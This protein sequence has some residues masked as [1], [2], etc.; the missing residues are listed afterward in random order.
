MPKLINENIELHVLFEISMALAASLDLENSINNIFEI[1]D[2]KMGMSRAT[3][4]ILNQQTNDI[5]INIAHGITDIEKKR[6]KYKLGEGVTGNVIKK[7]KPA[8]IPNIGSEPL[9]LNKT[10]ARGDTNKKNISFICVP[11]ISGKTSI[12]AI[13]VD[14]LYETNIKYDKD[15]Q[16]LTIIAAMIGQ[17]VKFKQLIEAEKNKLISEN[18]HL[19]YELQQ[20]YNIHN[21]VGNNNAMH[22]IFEEIQLVADSNA[23]V[24][25][26]GES[27]T[28]KELAAYAIHYNSPRASKPFVK[29]NCGAIPENLLESELF[30]YEKGAFTGAVGQKQGK[31]ELADKGTLFFR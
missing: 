15:V 14:K 25:I 24:I 12:G 7:G 8:I 31:L 16:L 18:K 2:K 11:I 22:K 5:V 1:L 13:S 10:K 17:A 30:G 6:G 21:M 20:K 9:F 28:G 4:T 3:L 29:I 23:T 27:G 26:R 19:K